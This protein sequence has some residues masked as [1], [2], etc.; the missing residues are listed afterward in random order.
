MLFLAALLLQA[1]RDGYPRHEVDIR[2]IGVELSVIE[3]ELRESKV[4]TIVRITGIQHARF[5]QRR[6]ARVQQERQLPID[7]PNPSPCDLRDGDICCVAW[8]AK[9]DS[10]VFLQRRADVLHLSRKVQVFAVSL[11]K[12]ALAIV[13]DSDTCLRVVSITFYD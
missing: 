7:Y 2:D 11:E 6:S 4:H 8:C 3:G 5:D 9:W 13:L 10:A 1:D 12:A